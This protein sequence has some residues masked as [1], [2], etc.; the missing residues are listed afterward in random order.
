[1]NDLLIKGI[2]VVIVIT[3]VAVAGTAITYVNRLIE[4]L[5]CD[6][7]LTEVSDAVK[8]YE[9]KSKEPG[10]GRAKK[11]QVIAY[12]TAWLN[13][14]KINVTEQQLDVLIEAAVFAMNRVKDKN[15]EHS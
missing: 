14:K 1:M 10:Q 11:A 13:S 9:Q 6:D 4:S 7:L 15:N 12:I 2:A 8:A 3:I 5:D